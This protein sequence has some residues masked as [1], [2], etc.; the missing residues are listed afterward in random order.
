MQE[1]NVLFIDNEK[2]NVEHLIEGLRRKNYNVTYAD[3]KDAHR[4]LD[5]KGEDIDVVVLDVRLESDGNPKDISGLELAQSLN[6]GL[7]KVITTHDPT[8]EITFRVTDLTVDKLPESLVVMAKKDVPNLERRIRDVFE[9]SKKMAAIEPNA[10][11]GQRGAHKSNGS[12]LQNGYSQSLINEIERVVAKY[13]EPLVH[14]PVIE[15]LAKVLREVK[16]IKDMLIVPVLDNYEGYVCAKVTADGIELEP[17]EETGV[18]N[19]PNK[20]LLRLGVWFQPDPPENV[21]SGGVDILDGQDAE[22]VHFQVSTKSD[23]LDFEPAKSTFTLRRGDKAGIQQFP[24]SVSE[25]SEEHRVWV[26]V[27][28]KNRFIQSLP[29]GLRLVSEEIQREE[30]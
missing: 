18:V 20:G 3:P 8:L 12:T 16:E 5:E 13:T 25:E 10:L 28:Q 11:L 7:P 6:H 14:G 27:F 4:I 15:D 1:I 21:L 29:I 30:K 19:A 22:E 23:T 24:F 17:D 26:E 2:E 9:V